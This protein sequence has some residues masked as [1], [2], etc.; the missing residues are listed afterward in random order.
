MAILYGLKRRRI[1][2]AGAIAGYLGGAACGG[3][4]RVI[5]TILPR[6]GLSGYITL[7]ALIGALVITPLVSCFSPRRT[8]K[9]S[10]PVPPGDSRTSDWYHIIPRSLPGKFTLGL[11][12]LGG[13]MFFA[14]IVLGGLG[15]DSASF[16]AVGGMIVYFTG[17][18]ARLLFE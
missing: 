2:Q 3:I 7:A 11:I 10:A 6:G 8:R 17:C 14:G 12:I 18:A 15:H 1:N 4:A 13:A 5:C 16:F 9:K